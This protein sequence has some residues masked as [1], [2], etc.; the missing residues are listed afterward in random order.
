ME[1]SAVTNPLSF[2]DQVIVHDCDMAGSTAK[3]YPS[4]FEPKTQCFS[5]GRPRYHGALLHLNII[6]GSLCRAIQ[7]VT[8]L[9]EAGASCASGGCKNTIFSFYDKELST[10]S[11]DP[12]RSCNIQGR[13]PD[14]KL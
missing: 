3:A 1:E 7:P 13:K 2:I 9:G 12:P 8:R 5:K 14:I 10:N 6:V 11:A 4:Q